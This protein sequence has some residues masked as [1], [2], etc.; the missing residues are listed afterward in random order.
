VSYDIYIR[1]KANTLPKQAY[2]E[3]IWFNGRVTGL[4][5]VSFALMVLS[6]GMASWS[7]FANILTAT[8]GAADS[9]LVADAKPP[10][11]ALSGFNIGYFWMIANCFS[12]AGYVC[13]SL[14]L[15]T[16]DT[17]RSLSC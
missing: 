5:L 2:G 4:M 12:S 7:D 8:F 15:S 10:S 13:H 16:I 3:V 11:G 14:C 17:D 1:Y 6:S 9:T